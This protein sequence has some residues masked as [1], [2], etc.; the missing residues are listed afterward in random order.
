VR[1]LYN[2]CYLVAGLLL[3]PWLIFSALT[4][5]KYRQGW[6][7]KLT[8]RVPRREGS[9]SLAWMHAVSVGEV[10]LLDTFLQHF[11]A[12]FPDWEI[13]ITTTT[14]TGYELA[15]RRYADSAEVYYCPLDFSWAVGQMHRRIRP[16]LLV[17]AEL[18]LWPNLISVAHRHGTKV[19]IINGRLSEKS[20]QGYRRIRWVTASI[21]RKIDLIAA[22]NSAYAERFRVLGARDESVHVTGSMK[23]DGALGDRR[24]DQ[25]RRFARLAR[26]DPTDFVFLAGSTQEPEE[27]VALEAFRRLAPHFPR[28]RMILTPRH[29][30]RFSEVASLLEASEWPWDRR[31]RLEEPHA[32]ALVPAPEEGARSAPRQSSGGSPNHEEASSVHSQVDSPLHSPL[33]SPVHPQGRILLVD[34]IGEL[35]WWWGVSDVAFVGGSLGSRGGQNMLEP[36]GFGAAVCFGPN[37]R[38]F[39]D[40]VQ[41]LRE[42]DAVEVVHNVDELEAFLRH[43]LESEEFRRERGRRGRQVVQRHQGSTAR[44]VELVAEKLGKLLEPPREKRMEPG[45]NDREKRRVRPHGSTA[46]Q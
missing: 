7:V 26:I 12:R 36:A 38:N 10:M 8:G 17:L 31:T 42:A 37:T 43:C 29:A 46:C 21:L 27:E 14:R 40:V 28:L 22:Q 44:T 3:I 15:R 25:V 13:V 9:A 45:S 18:E 16:S 4:K 24:Q 6:W 35:R 30:E 11:R 19:V 33:Q 1:Y 20:F 23:F 41:L 39:R 5:G 2:S 32:A 34:T